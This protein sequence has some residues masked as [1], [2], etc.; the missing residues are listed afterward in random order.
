MG[1]RWR[2]VRKTFG[3]NSHQ[4][5]AHR[6]GERRVGRTEIEQLL[7]MSRS[8]SVEDRLIAAEN[9]CPCHVRKKIPEVWDALYRMMEDPVLRVRRAA[10]HTLE[11]GGA[12]NDPAMEPI[13]ER[14]L[15]S[16]TDPAVRSF[17]R[18]AALARRQTVAAAPV[19]W[20]GMRRGQCDFCGASD[21]AVDYDL[22]T[23][24]PST[25]GPRSALICQA[26]SHS[27]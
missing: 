2:A 5:R 22:Q 4:K 23:T 20:K 27:Y 26:C 11:D 17:A 10:W 19:K 21:R 9:L 15:R 13:L 18:R 7:E 16:E 1:K 3:M 8:E 12:P 25:S 24:I 14:I 6:V